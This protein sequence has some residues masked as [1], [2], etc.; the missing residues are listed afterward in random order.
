M[1]MHAFASLFTRL[2]SRGAD[3]LPPGPVEP[4]VIS[5]EFSGIP[6]ELSSSERLP[7]KDAEA[8]LSPHSTAAGV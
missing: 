8:E 4:P 7:A 5:D 1:A 3:A 2:F 6:A